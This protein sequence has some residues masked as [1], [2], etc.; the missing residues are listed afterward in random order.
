MAWEYLEF[1]ILGKESLGWEYS[2]LMTAI[3]PALVVGARGNIP[4]EPLQEEIFVNLAWRGRARIQE[5]PV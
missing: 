5:E 4:K 3:F 1:F 2:Q